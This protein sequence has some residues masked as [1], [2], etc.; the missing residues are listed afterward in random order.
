MIQ[1]T[2]STL[3]KKRK[4]QYRC[5]VLIGPLASLLWSAS[6]WRCTWVKAS[7]DCPGTRRTPHRH[8]GSLQIKIKAEERDIRGC[9]EP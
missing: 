2:D 4:N 6:I 3:R 7:F 5:R 8:C 9:M 1:G